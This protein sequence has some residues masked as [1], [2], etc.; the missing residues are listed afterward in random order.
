M[1]TDKPKSIVTEEILIVD[2]QGRRR[3]WLTTKAHFGNPSL[4]LFDE[5]ECERIS[6]WLDKS[7]S[8]AI[9]LLDALGRTLVG[10]AQ[11]ADGRIGIQISDADGMPSFHMTVYSDRSRQIELMDKD[12]TT[13]WSAP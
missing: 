1:E 10:L 5:A 11:M 3:A 2:G 12:G 6:I 7:Q 4:T 8:P 9:A 13:I